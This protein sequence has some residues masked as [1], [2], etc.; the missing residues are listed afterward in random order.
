MQ[1]ADA[2]RD[3]IGHQFCFCS[4][5]PKTV[6][7]HINQFWPTCYFSKEKTYFLLTAAKSKSEKLLRYFSHFFHWK[8]IKEKD[9]G[10]AIDQLWKLEI[11]HHHH[12]HQ[13]LQSPLPYSFFFPLF[14]FHLQKKL[15]RSFMNKTTHLWSRIAHKAFKNIKMKNFVTQW[16]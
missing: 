11:R 14:Q 2:K 9:L 6:F 15:Y 8:E 1:S 12:Q 4:D 3:M 13:H 10:A 7:A 5:K 16:I